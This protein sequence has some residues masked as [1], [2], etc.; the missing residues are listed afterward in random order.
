[1]A[2][3]GD[4]GAFDAGTD[5]GVECDPVANTGCPVSMKCALAR[6]FIDGGPGTQVA[7]HFPTCVPAGGGAS[8]DPCTF[9]VDAGLGGAAVTDSCE[10]RLTCAGAD[11]CRRLCDAD[12]GGCASGATCIQYF[13]Q[14]GGGSLAGACLPTCD[15]VTQLLDSN[16][17][18]CGTGR[19]C[20]ASPVFP[21][22][23]TCQRSLGQ[24]HGTYP[25]PAF[26]NACAAGAVLVRADN[27]DLVCA[28]TCRP[29][30]TSVGDTA[31]AGG[32][33]PY[34]CAAR[35]A[36]DAE[37]HYWWEAEPTHQS[38]PRSSNWGFCS[39]PSF[40]GSVPRCTTLDAGQHG[41]VGCAPK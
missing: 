18:T 15:V 5:A 31:D 36:P 16:G 22:P 39:D 41:T 9:E 1:M 24:A 21:G 11:G 20:F 33:A 32:V 35:G 3:A 40:M 2:D 14:P 17:A 34:S 6:T 26:L 23:A 30:P 4:A 28:S 13:G 19:G 12:G 10:A 8:G 29:A 37:C 25:M 38:T 7:F 27:G